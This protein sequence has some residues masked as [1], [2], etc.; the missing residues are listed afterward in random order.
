M[1]TTYHKLPLTSS[2]HQAQLAPATIH[3][4]HVFC[5]THISGGNNCKY[6]LNRCIISILLIERGAV[7][8]QRERELQ[9]YLT[10]WYLD[11]FTT[12]TKGMFKGTL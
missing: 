1:H 3:D 4:P 8:L 11:M 9:Y 2:W 10:N 6:M 5:S 12:V 7:L